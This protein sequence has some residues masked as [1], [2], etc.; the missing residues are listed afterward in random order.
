MINIYN[1]DCLD[2]MKEMNDNAFDLAIVDPPYQLGTRNPYQGGGFLSTRVLNRD[3]K[4]KNWD[5][6]PSPQYFEQL[7]RVSKN[8]VI[9]GGNYFDLPPTRCV[10]CWDKKQSWDN[11]SQWEMGWTSYKKTARIFRFDNRTGGKI[12]PTQKPYELYEWTLDTFAEKGW[13]ILDTHIG[14]GSIALACHDLGFDLTGFEIDSDYY[15]SCM[16]RL[17]EHQR[18]TKLFRG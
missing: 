8:Q 3:N 10:I 7:F 2:A 18:Q 5:V 6:A 9:W 14:S 13:K 16:K 1:R 12:H 17:K 4:I 11:F 15:D